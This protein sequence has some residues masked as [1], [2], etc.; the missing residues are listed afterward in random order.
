MPVSFDRSDKGEPS[1]KT[2]KAARSN[3]APT[4]PPMSAGARKRARRKKALAPNP[5]QELAAKV[6]LSVVIIVALALV[7]W[8]YSASQ[9]TGLI[10]EGEPIAPAT[11]T[12]PERRIPSRARDAA[13]PPVQPPGRPEALVP[14]GPQGN[15]AALETGGPPAYEEPEGG[16]VGEGIN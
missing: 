10:R 9:P 14:A 12:V 13:T 5:R 2:P 1:R 11:V 4:L 7:G 3:A 6:V 8:W 15:D 16:A